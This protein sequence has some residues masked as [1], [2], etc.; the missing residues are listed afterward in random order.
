[1][2]RKQRRE[3]YRKNI[4]RIYQLRNSKILNSDEFMDVDEGEIRLL[5]EGN[6]ED[7]EKQKRY[8]KQKKLLQELDYLL[9][10]R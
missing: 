10:K 9:R 4:N 7:R 8:N 2:N 5:K 1:M 6:H 3:F